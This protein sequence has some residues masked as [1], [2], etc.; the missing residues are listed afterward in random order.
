[1]ITRLAVCAMAIVC[2]LSILFFVTN[3]GKGADFDGDWLLEDLTCVELESGYEFEVEMLNQLVE[4]HNYCMA[5]AE[6]PADA[7]HGELHC[8]L[9]RKEG[10]FVQGLA[11]DLAA[12]YNIKCAK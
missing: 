6:S 12:V 11:N 7:G 5:Y 4:A 9:L 8:A 1:M 2:I 10:L 3:Q